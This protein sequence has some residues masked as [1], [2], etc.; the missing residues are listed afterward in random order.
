MAIRIGTTGEEPSSLCDEAGSPF[1]PAVFAGWPF[2]PPVEPWPGLPCWPVPPSFAAPDASPDFVDEPPSAD[3]PPDESPEWWAAGA[4]APPFALEEC[5]GG[6]DRVGIEW[7]PVA[8]G[9]ASEYWMP[10]ESA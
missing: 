1:P 7:W 6:S 4:A 8:V 2:D 5:A 3:P 9:G 10:L